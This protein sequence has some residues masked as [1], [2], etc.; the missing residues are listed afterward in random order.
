MWREQQPQQTDQ[1]KAEFKRI[2]QILTGRL[3]AVVRTGEIVDGGDVWQP[4][5][6]PDTPPGWW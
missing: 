3:T 6:L 4:E 1:E 5:G 2:E